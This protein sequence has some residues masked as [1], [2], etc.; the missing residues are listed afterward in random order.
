MRV[1]VIVLGDLG[2][3]PRMLYHA[4]ALAN[5]GVDVDLIGYDEA[6]PQRAIDNG[7]ITR[8]LLDTPPDLSSRSVRFLG[9]GAARVIKQSAALARLLWTRTRRPDVILVQAPPAVPVLTVARLAA[10]LRGARLV[11]D[12][13]NFGSSVLALRLGDRHP[14]VRRLERYER[15]AGRRADAHLC[16]SRA[17]AAALADRRGITD[18]HVFHDRPAERFEPVPAPER[19]KRREDLVRAIGL[20][21]AARSSLVVVPTGWGRDDDF[22]LLLAALDRCETLMDAD[23]S[24]VVL[25]T[26]RGPLRAH[27][28]PLFE[29]RPARRVHARAVWLSHDEY[30]RTLACA[31]LGVSL[32]RSSS[33]LDLPMKICDLF[34]AGVPVC[35]LDYGPCLAELVR[36]GENGLLFSTSD[37][38]AA[39]MVELLRDASRDRLERLR[40]GAA[41][42]ASPRWREGWRAEAWPVLRGGAAV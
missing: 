38:L 36:P 24:I 28:A 19:L 8:W 31:D 2:R 18:A 40:E 35:A 14:L 13:H 26:G 20:P 11:I 37:E 7:R 27:Y 21:T 9:G 4:E 12:W 16:V 22:D 29:R 5:E 15:A 3:S 30:P 34:G 41:A 42:S 23:E 25:L 6:L 32:H 1:S 10:R 33:G 17:M 39:Q